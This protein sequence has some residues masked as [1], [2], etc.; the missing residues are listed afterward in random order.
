MLLRLPPAATLLAL[1]ALGACTP[2]PSPAPV[3]T[4]ERAFAADCVAQGLKASFLKHSASD[5]IIL[6]PTPV[7]A[8]E[9]LVKM[10]DLKPG[11]KRRKLAWW[12]LWA[13]MSRSGDLGFTTGPFAFDDKRVGHYFTVWKK[14]PDGSWKWVFDAGMDADSSAEAVEGSP[15]TYLPPATAQS[16]S[17]ETATSEVRAA[18]ADLAKRAERD[19]PGAYLAHLADDGRVHTDGSPPGKGRAAFALALSPRGLS[20][21]FAYLGGGAS[22]AGDLVWTYG[23]AGWGAG[24]EAKKGHYARVWQKRAEGWRIVFDELVPP[25]KPP[26]AAP[27]ASRAGLD[28]LR[29]TSALVDRRRAVGAALGASSA[30]LFGGTRPGL[31]ARP[32]QQEPPLHRVVLRTPC[33]P[34]TRGSHPR[35]SKALTHWERP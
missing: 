26:P 8:H 33:H 27:P 9:D 11:E 4:A 6:S 28:R 10:P 1:G 24:A 34:G 31:R 30:T 3:V 16:G 12:P 20:A 23:N 19:L 18:E 14:Q 5:A 35:I 17:P 15:A 25:R 29:P 22:Q 13:G 21:E 2:A 32:G 7:N